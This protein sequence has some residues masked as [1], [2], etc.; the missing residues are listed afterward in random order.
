MASRRTTAAKGGMASARGLAWELEWKMA[1]KSSPDNSAV[2]RVVEVADDLVVPVQHLHGNRR[3]LVNLAIGH[4]LGVRKVE[5]IDV[6]RND[7]P[8]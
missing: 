3:L 5:G 2:S 4:A 7:V 6:D 1:S 8:Q